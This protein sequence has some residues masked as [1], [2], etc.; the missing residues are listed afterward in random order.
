MA[1][2]PAFIRTQIRL[3]ASLHQRLVD[4]AASSGRSL[5]AEMVVRMEQSFPAA[6]EVQ[7]LRSRQEELTLLD[8]AM[9]FLNSE[10]AEL[11]TQLQQP[12]KRK[13]R[14]AINEAIAQL[15]RRQVELKRTRLLTEIEIE[16][17]GQAVTGQA[18]AQPEHDAEAPDARTVPSSR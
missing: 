11:N 15:S 17:L 12:S 7:L 1:D 2:L 5:N 14:G 13:M 9:M 8:Q 10:I 4:A 6:I 16:R 18:P 3:P